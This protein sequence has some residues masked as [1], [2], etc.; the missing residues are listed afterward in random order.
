MISTRLR[1]SHARSTRP[2]YLPDG[3]FR[4]FLTR[5]ASLRAWVATQDDQITGHVALNGTT[6][7][8][9]M[10]AVASDEGNRHAIYVARLWSTPAPGGPASAVNC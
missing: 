2:I 9:V 10:D 8:P 1:P 7:A 6:S 3:D 5:P 4:R